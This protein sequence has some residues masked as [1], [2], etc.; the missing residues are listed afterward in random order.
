MLI[1]LINKSKREKNI[2]AEVFRWPRQ[3]QPSLI[4]KDAHSCHKAFMTTIR[5]LIYWI[6]WMISSEKQFKDSVGERTKHKSWTWR[7][8]ITTQTHCCYYD[9][10]V[11]L[12]SFGAI[13]HLATHNPTSSLSTQLLTRDDFVANCEASR[14]SRAWLLRRV[15]VLRTCQSRLES[16]SAR[17]FSSFCIMNKA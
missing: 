2:R 3:P 11:S 15:G 9:S 4:H 1:F 16:A 10:P 13:N 8:R 17:D 6:S 12:V 14:M 7:G 5:A